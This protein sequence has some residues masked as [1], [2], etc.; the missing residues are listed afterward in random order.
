M[1]LRGIYTD[2]LRADEAWTARFDVNM[3]CW[4]TV[5]RRMG[6][7]DL[8]LTTFADDEP[9][10]WKE[11]RH[12]GNKDLARTIFTDAKGV[13]VICF[14]DILSLSMPTIV[15]SSTL[16]RPSFW[17]VPLTL[18]PGPRGPFKLTVPSN[19]IHPPSTPPASSRGRPPAPDRTT[20]RRRT[21]GHTYAWRAG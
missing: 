2:S 9:E 6:H 15:V 10:G 4:Q 7:T 1:L 14:P 20:R 18:S 12:A 13:S 21:A 5:S 19:P 17:Q 16:H 3:S 11:T 8:A